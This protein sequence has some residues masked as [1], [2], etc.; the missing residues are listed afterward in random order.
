[1]RGEDGNDRVHNLMLDCK[2]VVELAV[3]VLSPA[4]PPVTASISCGVAEAIAAP[5]YT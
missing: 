2:D 1:M 4:V 5:S 3:I